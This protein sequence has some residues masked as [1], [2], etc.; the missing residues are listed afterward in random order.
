MDLASR[1]QARGEGWRSVLIPRGE[2]P[3]PAAIPDFL[4]DFLL[5]PLDTEYVQC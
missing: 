4:R 2:R 5:H 3:G 1:Q